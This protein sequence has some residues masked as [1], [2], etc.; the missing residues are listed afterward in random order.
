MCARVLQSLCPGDLCALPTLHYSCTCPTVGGVGVYAT[1]HLLL[2]IPTL[3]GAPA[4]HT[5][6]QL[7]FFFPRVCLNRGQFKP[8]GKHGRRTRAG[9]RLGRAREERNA[10]FSIPGS[11]PAAF[12][13]P[14]LTHGS[15]LW[16]IER[17]PGPCT[18]APLS[19]PPTERAKHPLGLT[20][21]T[22]IQIV[23]SPPRS[24][25]N[26]RREKNPVSSVTSCPRRR[27]AL[28]ATEWGGGVKPVVSRGERNVGAAR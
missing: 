27:D 26:E 14:S 25:R 9:E 6:P 8:E 19:L 2:L 16:D 24:T 21:R 7:L 17:F 15:H 5:T 1:S 20:P 18:Y 12:L 23:S 4:V 28:A 13:H 3:C 22:V 11:I 10:P